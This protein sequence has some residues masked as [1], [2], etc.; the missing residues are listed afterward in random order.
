MRWACPM[1]G[2]LPGAGIKDYDIFY[3]DPSDLSEEAESAVQQR[4]SWMRRLEEVN[5]LAFSTCR[6]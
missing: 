6:I 1:D 2:W 4:W 5:I 3:F